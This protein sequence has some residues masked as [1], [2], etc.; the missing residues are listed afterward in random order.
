MHSQ[1]FAA[2]DYSKKSVALVQKPNEE[3]KKKKQASGAEPTEKNVRK[4]IKASPFGVMCETALRLS[5]Q[6]KQLLSVVA[7]TKF[8]IYFL[9]NHH[10]MESF[11]CFLKMNKKNIKFYY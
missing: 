1:H 6:S 8:V 4:L 11:C 3:R 7:K 5:N 10:M 2:F 9:R